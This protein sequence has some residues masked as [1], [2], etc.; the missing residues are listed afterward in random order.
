M[1]RSCHPQRVLV[2]YVKEAIAL[3]EAGVK[4][5]P[6]KKAVA[7]KV[8]R[9]LSA[10]LKANAKAAGT[11]KNLSVSCRNE[12]VLWITQAKQDATRQKRL[13][14]TVQWLEE[15]KSRNGKYDGK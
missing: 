3:N 10:A 12:Y 2:A 11:F 14:T 7:L 5:P 15:G 9:E 13:A 8:P 6:R 1:F 4:R